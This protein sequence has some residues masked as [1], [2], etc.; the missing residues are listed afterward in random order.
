MR[1]RYFILILGFTAV[2]LLG[3]WL[4]GTAAPRRSAPQTTVKKT[5]VQIRQTTPVDDEGPK[6]KRG[7]RSPVFRADEDASKAGALP[8]QRV[9]VFKDRS[10]LEDF[11]KRAGDKIRLMG[12][13][14]ALNVLRVG[15]LNYDDL[16]G[17][18]SGE[19]QASFIFPVDIPPNSD[20]KAQA[21]AVEMGAG[22][23]EWLGITQ[24]N[25]TWGAGVRIAVLD[26]GVLSN[27][28]FQSRITSIALLGLGDQ[29]TQ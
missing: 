12:R 27:P 9:L 13:L 25:S 23:L 17:L 2:G 7:E 22:L 24:D 20:G 6:F 18:L 14:D 16:A 26:T 1:R 29:L 4:A 21:G 15:F 19:E 28:A 10:A 3:Y 11:L 8:G 5:E